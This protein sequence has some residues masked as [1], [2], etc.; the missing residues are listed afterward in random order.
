MDQVQ[1]RHR[2]DLW[3]Y[4]ER[5]PWCGDEANH[6]I[7]ACETGLSYCSQECARLHVKQLADAGARW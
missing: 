7:K 4:N 2:P 3:A 1:T 6:D 5:C